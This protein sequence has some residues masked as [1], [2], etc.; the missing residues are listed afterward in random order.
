MAAINLTKNGFEEKVKQGLVGGPED[1]ASLNPKAVPDHKDSVLSEE[2]VA[3]LRSLDP[4]QG[5]KEDETAKNRD[6]NN[7]TMALGIK[8]A[9]GN[10]AQEYVDRGEQQ[11]RTEK[12]PIETQRA[13]IQ[14]AIQNWKHI[15]FEK[16]SAGKEKVVEELKKI[17]NPD[18][19]VGQVKIA[20]EKDFG[21]ARLQELYDRINP[22]A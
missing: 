17:N 2:D 13:K 7:S 8:N 4:E 3:A 22:Y 10:R 6:W 16:D 18:L 5:P 21:N 9:L 12:E 1:E 19:V 15:I 20:I 14:A 11:A